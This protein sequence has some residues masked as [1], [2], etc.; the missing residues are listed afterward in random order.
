VLEQVAHWAYRVGRTQPG[1]YFETA[2]PRGAGLRL[3]TAY[4]DRMTALGVPDDAAFAAFSVVGNYALA[5]GETAHRTESLGGLATE[6]VH[7][8]LDDYADASTVARMA[9]LM[10]ETDVESWFRRGLSAVLT[11]VEHELLP[12]QRGRRS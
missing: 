1:W 12:K 8:H 11:G 9:P 4:L 3:L 7:A 5:S 6:N 2:A 10:A